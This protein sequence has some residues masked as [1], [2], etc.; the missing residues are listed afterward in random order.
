MSKAIRRTAAFV[1]AFGGFAA[2]ANHPTAEECKAG[3]RRM[4][5]IQ[6]D[7]M[8]A[9]GSATSEIMRADL[10]EEQRKSTAQFLKAGI[11]SLLKPAFVA[12]CVDRPSMH[13]V[14]EHTGG[15]GAEV[16]LEA[17]LGPSRGRAGLLRLIQSNTASSAVSVGVIHGSLIPFPGSRR[18]IRA[19]PLEPAHLE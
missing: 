11:P 7:A 19:K 17:R 10:T 14:G 2:C 12:Q 18:E 3:I 15:T 6:I 4:M 5:E 9:P 8:D 1:L 13:D 16:P